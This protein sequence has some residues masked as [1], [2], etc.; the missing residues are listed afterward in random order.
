[1]TWWRCRQSVDRSHRGFD[2]RS[3]TATQWSWASYSHFCERNESNCR[4]GL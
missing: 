3:C 2:F 1:M 4:P